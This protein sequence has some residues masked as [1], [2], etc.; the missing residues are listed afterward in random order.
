MINVVSGKF[1]SFQVSI[2]LTNSSAQL[3]KKKL[4]KYFAVFQIL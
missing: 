1:L 2:L 4:Q 3:Y